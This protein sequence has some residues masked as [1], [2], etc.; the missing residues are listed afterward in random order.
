MNKNVIAVCAAVC[1]LFMSSCDIPKDLRPSDKA[2]VDYVEPGTRNT[3]NVSDAGK[4]EIAEGGI[5]QGD[6]EHERVM[7]NHDQGANTIQPND[8]INEAAET[9]TEAGAIRR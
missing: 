2:S 7:P 9:N 5:I 4:A 8:S 6:V 1:G 3:F